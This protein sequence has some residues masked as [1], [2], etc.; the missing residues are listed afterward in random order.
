MH[1]L[2]DMTA[3][4]LCYSKQMSDVDVFSAGWFADVQMFFTI[5]ERVFIRIF[6]FCF[7]HLNVCKRNGFVNVA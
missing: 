3:K 2:K 5:R 7:K 4:W 6:G 1:V